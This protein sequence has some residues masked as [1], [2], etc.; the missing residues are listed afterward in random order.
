MAARMVH[1]L[2]RILSSHRCRDG[3]RNLGYY[4]E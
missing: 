1:H 3:V 4:D 2:F